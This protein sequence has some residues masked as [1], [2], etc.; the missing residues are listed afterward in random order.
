MYNLK[1]IF[2]IVKSFLE[3]EGYCRMSN[4][5]YIKNLKKFVFLIKFVLLFFKVIINLFQLCYHIYKI[6]NGC[7][8]NSCI[9]SMVY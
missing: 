1:I 7:S 3:G 6:S 4:G 9:F 2:I 5:K 8:K